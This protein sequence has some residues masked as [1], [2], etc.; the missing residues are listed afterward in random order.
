[1]HRCYRVVHNLLPGG[2]SQNQDRLSHLQYSRRKPIK[3]G[4][5]WGTTVKIAQH[6]GYRKWE[7][8]IA[9]CGSRFEKRAALARRCRL[10]FGCHGRETRLGRWLANGSRPSSMFHRIW[11]RPHGAA[12][13]SEPRPKKVEKSCKF[14]PK[15]LQN[16]LD[17]RRSVD[18]EFESGP[19]ASACYSQVDQTFW[20][21]RKHFF[22]DKESCMRATTSEDKKNW[23][24]LTAFLEICFFHPD[25][26]RK[27]FAGLMITVAINVLDE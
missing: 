17:I 25:F 18:S 27:P 4:I 22:N 7:S 24:N 13:L 11:R 1:M 19:E 10:E 16:G 8:T 3:N 26:A 2:H 14:S 9:F 15:M 6:D 12:A 20:W 23:E 5:E 21:P